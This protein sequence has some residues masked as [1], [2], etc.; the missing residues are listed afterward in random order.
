MLIALHELLQEFMQ[1]MRE[2]IEA[3]NAVVHGFVMR[4]TEKFRTA[5]GRAELI[6]ELR[7]AQSLLEKR[8]VFAET[9]LNKCLQVLGGSLDELRTK[10]EAEFLEDQL[11]RITRH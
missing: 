6:S 8:R 3:R 9:T 11:S 4:N 1:F 7:L 5:A 2:G 10:A